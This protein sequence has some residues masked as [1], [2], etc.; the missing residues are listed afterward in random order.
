MRIQSFL[1]VG[2]LLGCCSSAVE[3]EWS[4]RGKGVSG[5]GIPMLN[6][7]TL[8]KQKFAI[9]LVKFKTSRGVE[10]KKFRAS[11]ER[12]LKMVKT[13]YENVLYRENWNQ[14]KSRKRPRF[15]TK[16]KSG[17]P[18]SNK[19]I[20]RI[21]I[22]LNRFGRALTTAIRAKTLRPSLQRCFVWYMQGR[23]YFPLEGKKGGR[24]VLS[25]KVN[26]IEVEKSRVERKSAVRLFYERIRKKRR[27]R[28]R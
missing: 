1:L 17:V 11:I 13:C 24:A 15:A 26:P 4:Y 19:H 23:K 21:T 18:S 7:S 16:P 6:A 8:V 9:Q 12:K 3:A 2:L 28:R 5:K 22:K 25:L 27:R 10:A 20:L 14:R